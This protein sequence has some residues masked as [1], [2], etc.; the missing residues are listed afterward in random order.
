MKR[1]LLAILAI[2]LCLAAFSGC[3]QKPQGLLNDEIY[4]ETFIVL[5]VSESN[6]LVAGIGAG[7]V[8]IETDQ[9]IVP[10]WFY[11]ST[12]I[13]VG[14]KVTIYHSGHVLETYPIQF[15][16]IQKMEYKDS[17]GCITT[18]IPD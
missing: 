17:D 11:P 3:D 6:I 10:N 9:C 14:D 18:V 4:Y 8:A 2:I 13:K 1:I 7:G 16:E 15:A 5:E 12:D